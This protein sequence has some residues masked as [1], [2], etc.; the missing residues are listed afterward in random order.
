MNGIVQPLQ[1]PPLPSDSSHPSPKQR[2]TGKVLLKLAAGFALLAVGGLLALPAVPGPGIP[3]ILLG[4]FL[5]QDHFKWARHALGWMR[6]RLAALRGIRPQPDRHRTTSDSLGQQIAGEQASY[7]PSKRR[8]HA[9]GP[10]K[11]G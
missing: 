4:L 2:V 10:G 6:K 5:L 11:A 7:E 9:D 1:E 3:I 8:P